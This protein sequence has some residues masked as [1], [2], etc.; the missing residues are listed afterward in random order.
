MARKKGEKPVEK[1][2]DATFAQRYGK[3]EINGGTGRAP[4]GV[5]GN[6]GEPSAGALRS[7]KL[8]AGRRERGMEKVTVWL[9]SELSQWLASESRF[10]G[11]TKSDSLVSL[12]SELKRVGGRPAI[13]TATVIAKKGLS[14][15]ERARAAVGAEAG[16][17]EGLEARLAELESSEARMDRN[18]REALA[19]NEQQKE[20][21]AKSQGDC[22][23]LFE[24]AKALDEKLKSIA[25]MQGRPM[26]ARRITLEVGAPT[27]A[28]G[29]N[30]AEKAG[31]LGILSTFADTL[32]GKGERYRSTRFWELPREGG[33]HMTPDNGEPALIVLLP[34]ET[35]GLDFDSI[36]CVHLERSG[37]AWLLSLEWPQSVKPG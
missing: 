26:G 24:H 17:C 18:Q 20:S 7:R 13:S 10:T 5:A 14:A 9:P 12:L 29:V 3:G 28:P 15:L 27:R 23:A 1:H 21:F 36:S 34:Q 11:M 32:S 31:A 30:G 4:K 33:I 2:E 16:R 37:G 19:L 25:S 6:T 35:R 22:Y 8:A